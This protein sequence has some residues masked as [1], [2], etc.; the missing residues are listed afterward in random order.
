VQRGD[1]R[2]DGEGVVVEE[3]RDVVAVV[4]DLVPRALHG[5]FFGVRILQFEDGQ[6]QAVDEEDEI[7]TAVVAAVDRKLI[8]DEEF[9]VFRVLPIDGIDEAVGEV[10]GDLSRSGH[11]A[12]PRSA[13]THQ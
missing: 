5:G 10:S 13:R 9:V 2:D 11:R 3:L 6:R 1:A 8:G 7:G 4:L 12:A